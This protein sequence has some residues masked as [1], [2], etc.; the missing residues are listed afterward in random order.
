MIPLEH[1]LILFACGFVGGFC[2]SAPL[3]VINLWVTDITLKGSERQLTAFLSGVI[4]MDAIYGMLALWGYHAV[5]PQGIQGALLAIAG[6]VFILGMG[7]HNLW[8]VK[9]PSQNLTSK[10]GNTTWRDFLLGVFLVVSNPAFLLF[11]IF[12]VKM[13]EDHFQARITTILSQILFVGGIIAGDLVWFRVL[14][15]MGRRGR[16][17]AHPQWLRRLR[18]AIA[19]GF[20]IFGTWAV[21][22]GLATALSVNWAAG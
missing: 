16:R 17:A 12:A 8:S 13:I 18:Q 19:L 5:S 10:I 1:S 14:I 7:A 9:H 15:A 2:S 20:L 3:G 21:G 22:Q 6:G 4:A 11:W